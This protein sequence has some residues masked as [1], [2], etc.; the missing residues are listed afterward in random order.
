MT[1]RVQFFNTDGRLICWYSTPNKSKAYRYT[2][3]SPSNIK[4]EVDQCLNTM[5]NT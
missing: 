2:E 3:K 5:S 4:V 1:Y